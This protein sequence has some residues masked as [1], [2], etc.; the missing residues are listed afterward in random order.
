MAWEW[1]YGA[2]ALHQVRK[3][4]HIQPIDWLVAVRYEW[5]CCDHSNSI[6]RQDVREE[7][8][9]LGDCP[10]DA[11]G[12]YQYDFQAF[13]QLP[14]AAEKDFRRRFNKNSTPDLLADYIYDR[15]EGH[16]SCNNGGFSVWV[17]PSGCHTV[18]VSPSVTYCCP[19]CLS[20]DGLVGAFVRGNKQAYE[21]T[22]QEVGDLTLQ[23]SS[24]K[25]YD[26]DEV[27]CLECGYCDHISA[28]DFRAID[29]RGCD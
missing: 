4:L 10:D 3:N 5:E 11:E 23:P 16:S 8:I 7:A 15:A 28:F 17:C 26:D 22:D 20:V 25:V 2:E 24:E 13:E 27:G 9:E 12:A 19:S 1:S 18:T 6:A 21:I 29:W 14:V